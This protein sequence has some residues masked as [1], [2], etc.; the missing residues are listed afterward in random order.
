MANILFANNASALLAASITDIETTI[1]VAS[2]FGANFPSPS[3]SEYFMVTLEDDNGDIE[4]VKCTSRTGDNLTV[5]R[6]QEGTTG[7]AF[8]LTVTRVELRLT[9]EVVEGFLQLS[10]GT[11]TGALAMGANQLS[12]SNV[13]FTGGS[14]TG[15]TDLAIADGGTAG[16]TA[17]DARQNLGLEIGVDVQA[18]D[19][20]T[21]KL[22]V[23][24]TI[25]STKTIAS[26]NS[27][28]FADT[29]GE[30]VEFYAS[31][32]TITA[33]AT[34]GF[35]YWSFGGVGVQIGSLHI[36]ST[37]TTIERQAAGQLKVEGDA[38]FS[39]A[40]STGTYASAKVHV[41]TSAPA[42]GTGSI[43]D[44]YLEREA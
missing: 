14:I 7:Q 4:I 2:G 33:I 42:G 17:A 22:D 15:I 11:M 1:Q 37:D 35:G 40:A 3:G 30:V 18:Y 27:L 5:V 43:G 16:S 21:M 12:G 6:A 38:I 19:V 32:N 10:G 9:K 28:K 13:A 41:S 26:G 20:D 24:Q 8:T 39:H 34:G 23:N 44:I 36:G 31:G 25:N 29:T